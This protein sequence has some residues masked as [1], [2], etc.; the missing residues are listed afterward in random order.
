M[1]VLPCSPPKQ[2]QSLAAWF[3]LLHEKVVGVKSF[4]VSVSSSSGRWACLGYPRFG[5]NPPPVLSA[6]FT[7]GAAALLW[8][9]PATSLTAGVFLAVSVVPA[10]P[11]G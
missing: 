4:H 9:E 1:L 8:E 5:Q 7:R 2:L 6:G 11:V 3:C 10:S